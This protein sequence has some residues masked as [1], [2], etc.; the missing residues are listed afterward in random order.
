MVL[1]SAPEAIGTELFTAAPDEIR[2]GPGRTDSFLE[3]PSFDV[4]GN[5]YCVDIPHGRVLRISP[6]GRWQVAAEY[7]GRPN[8]LKIHR[9][10]RIFIA[11]RRNGLVVL[12]PAS[13]DVRTVLSGPGRQE[14]FMGLNDL[15]FAANGDLYFTDRGKAACTIPAAGCTATARRPTGSNA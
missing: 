10:G 2:R 4:Q 13:G 8:G 11:D 3:G 14:R 15:V 1:D 12:D 7:D 5:L 6:D 9:D